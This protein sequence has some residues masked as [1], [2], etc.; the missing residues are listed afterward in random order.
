MAT[1]QKAKRSRPVLLSVHDVDCMLEELRKFRRDVKNPASIFYDRDSVQD[2]DD[3]ISY[4]EVALDIASE[5]IE[6]R[7]ANPMTSCGY[8]T[9]EEADGELIEQCKRCK[10][11][12]E[13][14]R[15]RA[16]LGK[17]KVTT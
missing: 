11:A 15:L 2:L 13:S 17:G 12:D 3:A 6:E 5:K 10:E 9:Y 4:V 1:K 16:A 8:C 14:K 7:I